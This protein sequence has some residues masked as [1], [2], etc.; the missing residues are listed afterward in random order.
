MSNSRPLEIYMLPFLSPGHMIPL[1]EI[2]Q[3]F[4]SAAQN[5]TILTTPHNAASLTKISNSPNFRIQT[6]SFPAKQVGLP[7]G[8]ENFLSAT[9]I[10]TATKLYTAVTLLQAD[11]ESFMLSSPPDVII[12]DM[13]FPWTAD[14][15]LKIGV[16]RIV[17]HATFIFAQTLKNA[18]REPDSPHHSVESDYEPFVIPNLP[19]KIT[20]TR[21]Q[22]PDYVRTPNGYTQLMEQWREA[23]L[24]SYGIVVNNFSEF[25]SEYTA[26]YKDIMGGKIKIFHVGPTSLTQSSSNDKANRV[27]KTVIAETECLSWLNKKAP[28]SVIYV[29][30]GSACKFPDTQLMEIACALESCGYDFIWAVLGKDDEKDE[31]MIKWI[32]S[33]FNQN[34]I[35]TKRGLIIKGWAPQVLI[36]D[37]P[38]VGGFLSHCGGNS[39]IESVSCGVPIA[40]W[41]LYAEHFYLEKMLTQVYG[42]GVEV[43]VEDWNLWVDCGK[44]IIRREK[45]EKALRKLM[46]GEDEM[47][48]EMRR[49]IKELG[50]LAKKAVQVGGSSHKN[51]MVLIEELKQIRDQ[52]S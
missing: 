5:V 38:S 52:K 41:P 25:E 16:P 14:F 44:K 36:L 11:L 23:E 6:F 37:H 13:F 24:K 3:L 26:F 17:F 40:T 30:F 2:G 50:E 9:D 21:A 48:K 1:S 10:P 29:C 35:K 19:H 51:L 20:M 42:I 7:D 32:P 33:D 15:A 46:D 45:I 43:G 47:V 4:S 12:S 49:K 22:L 18:V 39:V 34:V 27:H 28:N 8:L 31:D